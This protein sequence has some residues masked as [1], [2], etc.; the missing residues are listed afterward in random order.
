MDREGPVPAS[1]TSAF[2]PV[3]VNADRELPMKGSGL[4]RPLDTWPIPDGVIEAFKERKKGAGAPKQALGF[5]EQLNQVETSADPS[6]LFRT[7]ASRTDG[8][9]RSATRI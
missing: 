7:I 1:S 9:L 8:K 5:F 4:D 2:A 6:K 3:L